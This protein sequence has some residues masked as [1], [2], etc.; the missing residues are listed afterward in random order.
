MPRSLWLLVIGMM[1]NV[2]GSSFLWPLNTIYINDHLGKSLTVAGI[3][4]MLNSAASVA[5]NLIGGVLFDRYGGY[6]SIL[7]GII[8]TLAAIIG[9]VFFHGWPTYIVFLTLVGFGSG[10]VFPSMYA[11]AG[12]VWPEG[13]RKAF[14]AIYVSQN[15]GVAVGAALGGIIANYSFQWIFI[16][17][18]A[19]YAVFFLL[20]CFGY[21]NIAEGASAQT[22]ILQQSSQLKNKEKFGALI[23]LCSGYL[24]AWV[25]Y[26]QWQSTIAA[27]TQELNISLSQYSLIWTVN[28]ALIVFAQPLVNTFVKHFAKSIKKQMMIGFCIFILSFAVVSFAEEFSMFMAAMIILTVGE[29]LVWPAVPTI[30]NDLAPKGR[31]GFYQGFVNSTATGGRMIGPLLGGVLVDIYG[32]NMLFIVLIGLLFAAMFTTSIYDKKLK[33]QKVGKA[34]IS[35]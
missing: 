21:R 35:S 13:R 1:I 25:A 32:M 26:V 15:A 20:A 34:V 24:L 6:R 4:L 7:S 19:L 30:A 18:A 33:E 8:L 27:H 31:E 11:M 16:A 12:T 23:I 29:M 22:S 9:L 28:G 2:T 5:G 10:I 14:N 3:V 17:N